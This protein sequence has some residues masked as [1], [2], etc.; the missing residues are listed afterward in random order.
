MLR[1]GCENR[2]LGF[3]RTKAFANYGGNDTANFLDADT[4]DTLRAKD[5]YSDLRRGAAR[6]WAFDFENVNAWATID[7]SPRSTCAPRGLHLQ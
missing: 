5:S 7:E 3:A 6:Q 4:G 2:V 1:T